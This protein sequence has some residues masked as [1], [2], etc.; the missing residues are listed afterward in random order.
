MNIISSFISS[1]ITA[2]GKHESPQ[3][4]KS[5]IFQKVMGSRAQVD[6]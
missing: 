6:R 2:E 3:G 5:L 4:V 1:N